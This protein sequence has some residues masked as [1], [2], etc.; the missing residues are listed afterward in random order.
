MLIDCDVVVPAST[1]ESFWRARTDRFGAG[2]CRRDAARANV[3][4]TRRDLQRATPRPAADR[5]LHAS[6]R[7]SAATGG[8]RH[9]AAFVRRDRR[10]NVP[11][12]TEDAHFM[13]VC[14]TRAASRLPTVPT[15]PRSTARPI[16]FDDY[17]RQSNR[18]SEGRALSARAL[19]ARD[20][21][22]LLR[23]QSRRS[24]RHV[25]TPRRC[26]DPLGAVASPMFGAKALQ[27]RKPPHARRRV[28][29]SPA[30][31]LR[32]LALRIGIVTSFPGRRRREE[33]D[34]VLFADDSR[35][36]AR[37]RTTNS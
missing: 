37:I 36:V 16:R 8:F 2:E 1:L 14:M 10:S 25:R 13:L 31:A 33:F 24:A 35:S 9:V 3:L 15:P 4:G 32:D 30:E 23:S 12:H 20:P 27:R 21:G 26:A 22:A 11:R 28:G 5:V 34:R 6:S 19:A 17:L 18:F 29:A 7:R